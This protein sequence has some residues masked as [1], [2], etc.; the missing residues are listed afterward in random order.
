MTRY[1]V[2]DKVLVNNDYSYDSYHSI[3]RTEFV[4]KILE[5]SSI[6]QVK[7]SVLRNITST[8]Y[9][10]KENKFW[11]LEKDLKLADINIKCRK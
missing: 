1:K 5:I 11:F 7:I 2:G 4:G 8:C 9:S 6:M 10:V 3:P